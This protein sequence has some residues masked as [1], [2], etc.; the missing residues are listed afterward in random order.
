MFVLIDVVKLSQT[1]NC[2]ILSR[3]R[4]KYISQLF[5]LIGFV[6]LNQETDNFSKFLYNLSLFIRGTSFYTLKWI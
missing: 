2:H 5:L 3:V 6:H 1:L 4:V